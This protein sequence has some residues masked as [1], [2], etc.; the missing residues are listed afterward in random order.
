MEEK[1]NNYSEKVRSLSDDQEVKMATF[2]DKLEIMKET[3]EAEKIKIEPVIPE[4]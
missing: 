4:V 3:I 2:N 1:N